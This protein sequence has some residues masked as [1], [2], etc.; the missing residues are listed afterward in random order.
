MNQI[1]NQI[2]DYLRTRGVS[3]AS[4]LSAA[5]GVSQPTLS[6][7]LSSMEARIARIGRARSTRYALRSQQPVNEVPVYLIEKSGKAA[8]LGTL[9]TLTKGEYYFEQHRPWASLRMEEF[10][11]GLYPGLPWFLQDMRP[12]GFLGRCFAR[13]HAQILNAPLN[14]LQWSN[15]HVLKSFMRFGTDMPGALVMGQEMLA[16]IQDPSETVSSLIQE[17]MVGHRYTELAEKS[18]SGEWPGSSAAGEQ[19]KF[20]ASLSTADGNIKHVIV[21]FS[22]KVNLPEAQ[23]W[24]DLLQA[25]DIANRVL[26]SSGLSCSSSRIVR[27]SERTF[28]ESE[29]FDRCGTN[30]RKAIVSLEALDA[31]FTG[32]NGTPWNRAASI[33]H[34]AGFIDTE[35]ARCLSLAWWFGTLIGNSDMHYGNISLFL[36]PEPPLQLTPLYDM[37]PMRYR[38]GAEGSLP[39]DTL[40]FIPPPPEEQE[41]WNKAAT[42]ALHFWQ[43]VGNADG[44]SASFREIAHRN[45]SA[46]QSVK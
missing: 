4:D 19:P 18:L 29:R 10:K 45:L 1:N 38:P 39:T 43:E 33:L 2:C 42:L 32:I 28:L 15:D 14:P 30:G 41:V 11:D 34:K 3:T 12:C 6:R 36:E 21:K 35:N 44:I 31:A 9:F 17:D 5:L 27:A 23:R 46:L 13:S 8:H 26:S 7:A 16:R 25:E 20:T 22:G 40:K 24:S 37:L